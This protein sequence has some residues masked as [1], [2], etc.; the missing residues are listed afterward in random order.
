MNRRR[1]KYSRRSCG[2]VT[3]EFMVALSIMILIFALIITTLYQVG[4]TNRG[5]WA[6]QQCL[7]GARAQLDCLAATGK[8][9]A[10]GDWQTLWPQCNCTIRQTPGTGDWQGLTR[11]EVTVRRHAE[12][13]NI[14]VSLRRY[15]LLK[16]AD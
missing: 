13:K 7:R 4:R 1:I 2:S 5:Q 9:V 8:P 10:E 3:V 11:V 16:E 12:R 14:Q 15:L 6:R